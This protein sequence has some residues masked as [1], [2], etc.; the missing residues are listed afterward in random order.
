VTPSRSNPVTKL[1]E[2]FAVLATDVVEQLR[3]QGVI[4]VLAHRASLPD[5]GLSSNTPAERS[6]S[7]TGRVDRSHRALHIRSGQ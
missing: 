4:C 2:P 5:L 3:N 7:T 1:Q 6:R